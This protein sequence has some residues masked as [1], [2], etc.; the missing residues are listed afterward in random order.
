MTTYSDTTSVAVTST[1]LETIDGKIPTKGQKTKAGSVPVVL[2]SDMGD[3]PVT[4]DSEAVVLGAGSEVIGRVGTKAFFVTGSFNRP[5]DPAAYTAGDAVTNSTS[6][7]TVLELALDAEG[8]ANAQSIMITHARVVVGSKWAVSPM[9]NLRISNATFTATNDNA[10]L[11][12][13]DDTTEGMISIPCE[14]TMFTALNCA[15]QSE[16][17]FPFRLAAADKSLFCELEIVNAPTP[18]SGDKITVAMW[19]YL[20]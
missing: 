3:L 6:A 19:G 1:T 9:F 15:A 8:A 12:I 5:A 13:D 10:A 17:W 11:S 4:L 18:G 7:P 20:L 2:P 14:R 16:A